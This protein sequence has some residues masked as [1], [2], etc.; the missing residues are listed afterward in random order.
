M[1]E[2]DKTVSQ[3]EADVRL[4]DKRGRAPDLCR[5]GPMPKSKE[6]ACETASEAATNS[7]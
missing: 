2:A 6:K 7:R 1:Q 4:P 5:N 3:H